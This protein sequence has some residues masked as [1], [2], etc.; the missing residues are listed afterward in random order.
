M[1]ETIRRLAKPRN[2]AMTQSSTNGLP[3]SRSSHQI[4]LPT[5]PVAT[6]SSNTRRVYRF[7]RNFA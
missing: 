6:T 3:L 4:R 2:V 1:N 5:P 7:E